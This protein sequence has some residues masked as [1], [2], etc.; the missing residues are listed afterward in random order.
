L[1]AAAPKELS[2]LGRALTQ[3]AA[4]RVARCARSKTAE[5]VASV[6]APVIGELRRSAL[7]LVQHLALTEAELTTLKELVRPAADKWLGPSFDERAAE[8]P[9]DSIGV[10]ARASAMTLASRALPNDA[11]GVATLYGELIL[12]TARGVPRTAG[13]PAYVLKRRA[14]TAGLAVCFGALSEDEKT[15][16]PEIRPIGLPEGSLEMGG[17]TCDRCHIAGRRLSA[18]KPP[19]RSD[20][21]LLEAVSRWYDSSRG[22][23]VSARSE[24]TPP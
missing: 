5:G 2:V 22:P 19:P 3:H 6:P 8:G 14:S 20:L 17:V 10:H 13:V 24:P 7:R 21:P 18:P 23:R 9:P 11:E 16:V 12:I 4:M 1:V 15:G